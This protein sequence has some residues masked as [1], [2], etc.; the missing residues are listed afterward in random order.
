VK[1]VIVIASVTLRRRLFGLSSAARLTSKA[2]S[3]TLPR[4]NV[5]HRR[6]RRSSIYGVL[7]ADHT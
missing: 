3:A 6:P 4:S 2:T 7:S 1:V 5:V